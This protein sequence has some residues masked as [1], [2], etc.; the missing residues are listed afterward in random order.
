V[1]AQCGCQ[2]TP[3]PGQRSSRRATSSDYSLSPSTPRHGRAGGSGRR[4]VVKETRFDGALVAAL[5]YN[6]QCEGGGV[7]GGWP[8]LV[9][10]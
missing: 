4:C 2:S 6:I 1:A 9:A 7:Y 3:R 5:L 8:T 10:T